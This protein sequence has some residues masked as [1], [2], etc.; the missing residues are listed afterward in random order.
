MS[1]LIAHVVRGMPEFAI[2][3]KLDGTPS[4]PGPWWI[5]T[6]GGWRVRPYWT[7]PLNELFIK[8]CDSLC[9]LFLPDAPADWPDFF[10][11]ER[12]KPKSQRFQRPTKIDLEELGL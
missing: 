8:S 6:T 5:T 9:S 10:K 2:A 11:Q 12:P 4:D 7:W 1:H 3:E